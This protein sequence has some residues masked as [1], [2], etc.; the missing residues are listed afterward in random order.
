MTE[1]E[2]L[3]VDNTDPMLQFLRGGTRASERKIRLFVVAC[4]AT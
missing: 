4:A 1:A 2:W 3:A